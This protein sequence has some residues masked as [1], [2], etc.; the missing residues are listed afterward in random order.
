MRTLGTMAWRS[1]R[2]AGWLVVLAVA[3]LAGCGGSP[4]PSAATGVDPVSGFPLGHYAK[5]IT[6]PVFGRVR[7]AWTFEPDGRFAEIPLALDGQALPWPAIRGTWTAD[8][9]AVTIDASY[10]E[11]VA[12]TRHGWR[13]DGDAL[14]TF[15]LGSDNPDDVDWFTALDIQ[16]WKRFDP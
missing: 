11:D 10:P 2:S 4:R 12:T 5:E 15:F 6:D 7:I 8:R 9:D 14:W 1:T 3:L 13:R 16:P